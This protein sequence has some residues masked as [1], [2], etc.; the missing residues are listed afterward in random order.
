M[1][2]EAI[3]QEALKM[4]KGYADTLREGLGKARTPTDYERLITHYYRTF[5]RVFAEKLAQSGDTLACKAGCFYCC[6][7][8]V[9]VLPFEVFYLVTHITATLDKG[10]LDQVRAKAMAN[11][12]RITS[13]T[14]AEQEETAIQCPLLNNEGC[15]MCYVARPTT[16]RKYHSCSAAPCQ[17]MFEGKADRDMRSQVVEVRYPSAA[18]FLAAEKTFQNAGLDAAAYDLSS[19]LDEALSNPS[20]YRRWRDGKSAFSKALIAKDWEQE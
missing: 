14:C 2:E 13:M 18:I 10:E 6:H 20:C 19:A 9:D 1:T 12:Q 7:I 4:G 8:K 15:C 17:A 16:C 11:R 3:M 5:D